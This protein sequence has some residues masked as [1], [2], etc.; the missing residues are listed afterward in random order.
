MKHAALCLRIDTPARERYCVSQECSNSA[1]PERPRPSDDAL[2]TTRQN[3]MRSIFAG[4][5]TPLS[6]DELRAM[7]DFAVGAM[8]RRCAFQSSRKKAK[9][10]P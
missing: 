1:K 8:A 4:N 7:I 10:A 3:F 2:I 6:T 9:K 5:G